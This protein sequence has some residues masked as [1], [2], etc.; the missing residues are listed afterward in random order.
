MTR[1]Y[2]LALGVRIV[3][4]GVAEVSRLVGVV[5]IVGIVGIVVVI[6]IILYY[7]MPKSLGD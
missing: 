2:S 6:W 4:V 3:G 1:A 7:Y 5:K